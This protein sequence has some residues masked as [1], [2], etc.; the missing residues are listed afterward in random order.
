MRTKFLWEDIKTENTE[1]IYLDSKG[2]VVLL[3]N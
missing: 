2:K 3:P 1:E